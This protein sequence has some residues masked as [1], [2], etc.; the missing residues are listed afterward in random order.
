M[1]KAIST[2]HALLFC[3]FF[4]ILFE[5]DAQTPSK[6]DEAQQLALKMQNG[7]AD[8]SHYNTACYLA[9]A[10]QSKLALAYLER[11]VGDGFPDLKT[12]EADTDLLSLHNDPLWPV[13]V[14]G[15]KENA[16]MKQKITGMYF[17]KKP[18]WESANMA[19]PYQTN[20]PENEKMAG[21]AKLW[22]ELKYN[23]V[24]FDLVP[25]VNLDSLY[26]AYLP[27]V[28]QTKST[29]EYYW[30]MQEL[31][32]QLKDGHTNINVPAELI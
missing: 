7:Q 15:V 32:A 12:F 16:R 26:F 28:R 24:N 3:I 10:G 13:L 1:N 4:L 27:K 6:T 9:L 18:F 31:T 22:S 19:T 23:F 11:A 30:V 20:I 14:N 25:N 5:C 8:L 29:L 2:I 21:L 17:N